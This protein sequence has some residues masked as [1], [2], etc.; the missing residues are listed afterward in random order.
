M[1]RIVCVSLRLVGTTQ[2]KRL[3]VVR[4]EG[5]PLPDPVREVRL[6]HHTPES[7]HPYKPTG[8]LKRHT[9]EINHRPNPIAASVAS[10]AAMALFEL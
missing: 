7:A 2:V 10:A 4:R 3:G 5:L 9:F 6:S 1:H 8:E